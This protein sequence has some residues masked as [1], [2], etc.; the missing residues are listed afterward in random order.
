MRTLMRQTG[1]GRGMLALLLL[2]VLAMRLVAPVGFMPIAAGDSIAIQ[3]C[4][5]DNG[6]AQ[7]AIDKKQPVDKHD[8]A[9][10]PC[11]F[12]VGAGAADLPATGPAL[13]PPLVHAA[14]LS[15]PVVALLAAPGLAA[16]PPPAI[17]PPSL[18]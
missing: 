15:V 3:F 11:A 2:L 5:G 13:R 16:P 18:R 12:A 17:G 9:D 6:V 1:T 7:I 8:A 14:L 10:K 4:G